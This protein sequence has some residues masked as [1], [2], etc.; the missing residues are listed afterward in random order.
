LNALEDRLDHDSVKK[1]CVDFASFDTLRRASDEW[2]RKA[3]ISTIRI[4]WGT[5]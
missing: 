5:L 3:R 2:G 4:G 1:S